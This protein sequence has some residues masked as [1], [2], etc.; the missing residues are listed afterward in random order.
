MLSNEQ[1]SGS[2]G[3]GSHV[4]EVRHSELFYRNGQLLQTP[5]LGLPA[6]FEDSIYG[7]GS[8]YHPDHDILVQ[9]ARG[10]SLP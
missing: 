3:A 5:Q 9:L 10:S 2:T 1:L 6:H 8:T 4:I 7:I